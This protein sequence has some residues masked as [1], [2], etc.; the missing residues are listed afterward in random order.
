MA[1]LRIQKS[2][3]HRWVRRRVRGIIQVD[4]GC[5]LSCVRSLTTSAAMMSP[6][7]EGTKAVEPGMSLRWVHFRTVPGG[8]TQCCLQ[9]MDISSRGR[10]GVSRE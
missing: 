1:P 4:H 8:Q 2:L 10:I 5:A 3:Q 9:L 7:A 6:A